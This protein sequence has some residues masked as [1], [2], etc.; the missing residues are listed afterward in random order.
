MATS[1][2]CIIA[3]TGEDDRY[4]RVA[5]AAMDI[6][7]AANASLI[8]YDIDAATSAVDQVLHPLSGVAKPTA[9]RA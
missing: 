9:S 4:T 8:F 5:R 6:A 2:T 7:R 1:P 3:Y